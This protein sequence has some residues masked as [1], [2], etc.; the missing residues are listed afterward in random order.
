MLSIHLLSVV[1]DSLRIYIWMRYLKNCI[2]S[3]RIS[4]KI[5]SMVFII[6]WILESAMFSS[7]CDT[8]GMQILT[9]CTIEPMFL[10]IVSFFYRGKVIRH[11]FMAVA[12]PIMYWVGKWVVIN[13]VFQTTNINNTQDFISSAI[14]TVLLFLLEIVL[15]QNKKDKQKLEHELLKQEIAIYEKQFELIRQSQKN[16]RSL[17]HDLKHHIKMLS[18]MVSKGDDEAALVYLS[19]MGNFMEN[20]EEYVCSGNER[21]DSI[22]NFMIS[23]AKKTGIE[24]DWKV[25]I[26]ENLEIST[27]DINVILSNL[28][29]NALNE[30]QNI[31]VPVLHIVVKFD[32]GVL[33][34]NIQNSCREVEK[35]REDVPFLEQSGNHG[36]GLNNVYRIVEKYHGSFTTSIDRGIFE[37]SVLLFLKD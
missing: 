14:T 9:F 5:I 20:Q 3:C 31:D 18:D 30:L 1:L 16:I 28:L 32:R 33:C 17:K 11:L 13:T 36:Y 27:F 7:G 8:I 2:G 34:I 29:D 10:L 21:L 6:W 24:V 35:P 37:V 15:E 22:L 25:Q 12:L 23:K 19:S 26:P 4:Q